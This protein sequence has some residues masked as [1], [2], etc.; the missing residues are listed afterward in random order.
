MPDSQLPYH[1]EGGNILGMGRD[2]IMNQTPDLFSTRRLDGSSPKNPPEAL[3]GRPPAEWLFPRICQGP[4][5]IW[6][7]KT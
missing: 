5:G 6:R 7:T 2:P 1:F 4:F 3:P